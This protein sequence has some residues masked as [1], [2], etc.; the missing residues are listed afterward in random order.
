MRRC[1]N[2]RLVHEVSQTDL[3]MPCQLIVTTYRNDQ[4]IMKE[5]FDIEFRHLT[6]VGGWTDTT[7]NEVKFSIPQVVLF[8][9]L[10]GE[11][12]YT[13][14][15]RNASSGR[16]GGMMINTDLQGAK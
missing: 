7:Q 9:P 3:A 10:Q 8:T 16:R 15:L 14:G 5:S 13:V 11:V 2:P 1:Q 6:L 4:L 12:C